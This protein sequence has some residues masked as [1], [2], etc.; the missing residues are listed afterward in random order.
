M[1]RSILGL[2]KAPIKL[3]INLQQ[4]DGVIQAGKHFEGKIVM[5]VKSK[6]P[7]VGEPIQ[8]F[9]SG[10]ERVKT[11][12][13]SKQQYVMAWNRTFSNIIWKGSQQL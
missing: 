1:I 9:V 11:L 4:E 10:R 7:I 5:E 13:T 2:E 3:S 6:E 12:R 8:L